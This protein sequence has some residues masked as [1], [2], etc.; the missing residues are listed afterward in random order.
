MDGL[1]IRE[2]RRLAGIG[3]I[4]LSER[5]GVTQG[6]ISQF[7]NNTRQPSPNTREA[8]SKALG[9]TIEDLTGQPSE[10][11]RL[12]RNLKELSPGCQ[13]AI[14][15]MV[16]QFKKG[17]NSQKEEDVLQDKITG[18][19]LNAQAKVQSLSAE[20]IIAKCNVLNR[21]SMKNIVTGEIVIMEKY[22]FMQKYLLSEVV[23]DVLDI[24][25]GMK[26]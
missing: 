17:K 1:K 11:I 18:A 10:F 5:I 7:E 22:K 13:L 8:I 3:Q 26:L 2:L 16:L 20:E 9:C 21:I 25:A 19:E 6:C 12:M 4:E 15:E 24:L 23:S 14:N